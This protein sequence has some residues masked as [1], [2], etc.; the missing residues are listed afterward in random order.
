M[1]RLPSK[2]VHSGHAQVELSCT[3]VQDY[4]MAARK[5]TFLLQV[6][7]ILLNS[8]YGLANPRKTGHFTLWLS[9]N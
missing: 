4:C 2:N 8:Y 6:C 5:G 7:K 9:L 3:H 1:L